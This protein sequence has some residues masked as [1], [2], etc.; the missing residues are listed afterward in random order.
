MSLEDYYY[1]FLALWALIAIGTFIG[2][3]FKVAPYGRYLDSVTSVTLPSR[4]GWILME[5]PTVIGIFIFLLMFQKSIGY[6]EICLSS[7]WLLHYIHR[8]F[9]WPFR[10]KLENK[11]MTLT[12]ILMAL[13]FNIVNITIQCLWIFILGEYVDEWLFSPFFLIGLS[14]FLIG[15]LINIK[16]DNILMNLRTNHG[17]GYH[18]PNGFLYRYITC[19]NYLGELIEWFGWFVLTMSPAALTFFVWTF[20][21][22]VPRAKSN[23][24]WSKLNIKNYPSNRKA[25]LPFVY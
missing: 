8:T 20:A 2:L 5:S 13:L 3:F 11:R 17:E 19:P 14:L 1:S 21:N 9:M 22:L 4:I 16:S 23:H 7:I 6:V 15:M 18:V 12:V 25:I 24:E 10:A